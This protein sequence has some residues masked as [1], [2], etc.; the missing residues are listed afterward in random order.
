[1]SYNYC[2]CV[3]DNT[4]KKQRATYTNGNSPYRLVQVNDDDVCNECGHY[5]LSTREN[6]DV[7]SGALRKHLMGN[8]DTKEITC[9]NHN[10]QGW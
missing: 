5:T 9:D 3:K 10:L 6:H 8:R 1:M 2:T 7:A 4:D